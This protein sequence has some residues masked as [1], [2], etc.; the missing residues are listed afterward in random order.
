[1]GVAVAVFQEEGLQGAG[2]NF[3]AAVQNC[4]SAV[5]FRWVGEICDE[6]QRCIDQGVRQLSSGRRFKSWTQGADKRSESWV[7]GGLRREI[8]SVEPLG[9]SGSCYVLDNVSGIWTSTSFL[10]SHFYLFSRGHRSDASRPSSLLLLQ[11]R[12]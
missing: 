10:L 2:L 9:E 1:M 7:F 3:L 11:L 5:A 12:R 6:H 4:R 8:G